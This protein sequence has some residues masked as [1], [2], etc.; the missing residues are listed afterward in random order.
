MDVVE[1]IDF[2]TCEGALLADAATDVDPDAAVR[3]VPDLTL[4]ELVHHVGGIH[5]WAT[6]TIRASARPATPASFR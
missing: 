4:R 6:A 2:L 1:H 3:T 5:R